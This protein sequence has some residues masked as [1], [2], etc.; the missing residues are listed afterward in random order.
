[1][2]PKIQGQPF[3]GFPADYSIHPEIIDIAKPYLFSPLQ[4]SCPKSMA[5]Q[6]LQIAV[7]DSI[8]LEFQSIQCSCNCRQNTIVLD[9]IENMAT[10]APNMQ[11]ITL[12]S[13]WPGLVCSVACNA[14]SAGSQFHSTE[15]SRSGGPLLLNRIQYSELH[16]SSLEVEATRRE[17]YTSPSQLDSRVGVG[18]AFMIVFTFG[19][20]DTTVHEALM[21]LK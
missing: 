5:P 8:S 13:K 12:E 14:L 3:H 16:T 9:A 18:Q 21:I 4:Q 10:L 17:S 20:Y 7:H 11:A 2:S 1:M 19:D 15:C 6:G